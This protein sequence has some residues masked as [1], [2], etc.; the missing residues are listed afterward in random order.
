MEC[1]MDGKINRT[2]D[3]DASSLSLKN[4]FF[5]QHHAR[6]E[7]EIGFPTSCRTNAQMG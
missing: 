4:L 7:P 1:L 3:D 5:L 6:G 2:F